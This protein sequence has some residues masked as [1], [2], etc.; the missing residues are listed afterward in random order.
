MT[1]RGLALGSFDMFHVGHLRALRLAADLCDQL[2][3]AV[4][5]DPLVVEHCGSAPLVGV[6]ERVEVVEGFEIG[7][8]VVVVDVTDM[9]SLIALLRVDTVILTTPIDGADTRLPVVAVDVQSTTSESLAK[10]PDPTVL[11][12]PS[13]LQTVAG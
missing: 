10:I 13:G 1:T 11:W 5:S 2:V 9:E 6:A 12:T 7:S 8:E 3:I 4:V